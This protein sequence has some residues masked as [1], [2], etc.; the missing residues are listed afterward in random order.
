VVEFFASPSG[1]EGKKFIGNK[2][3]STDA[4]GDVAF[5]FAPSQA[6]PARQKI[7]ATATNA[8]EANTSEFSAPKAVVAQ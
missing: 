3:V 2:A 7:T 8:V 5:T 1:N 4:N 6:V